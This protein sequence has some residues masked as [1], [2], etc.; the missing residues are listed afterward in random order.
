MLVLRRAEG[1]RCTGAW[2]TVHGSM[3]DGERPEEAAVRELREETGLEPERLY[4]VCVNPFYLHR[5]NVVQLSIVFCAF[6]GEE[7][8][9][10]PGTEHDSYEWLSVPEA[11]ARLA[12]P[13]ERQTLL[14]AYELLQGGDA[15]AVEDVLRVS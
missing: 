8:A 6:V 10:M 7:G 12:W 2:E 4:N 11:C 15:G 3:E 14:E 1:T 13:R 5:S 9:V